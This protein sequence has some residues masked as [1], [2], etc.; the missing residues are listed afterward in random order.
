MPEF[1][2]R[3]EY[4][5][6]KSEKI[7]SNLERLQRYQ[8]GREKPEN[9]PPELQGS[10]PLSRVEGMRP[11]DKLF[12]ESWELYKVRFLTLISLYLL[13]VLLMLA[14]LGAFVGIA[15]FFSL[16]F[17]VSKDALIAGGVFVGI[18]SGF[19]AMLWGVAAFT[20]AVVDE[21]TGI[22]DALYKGWQKVSSFMW[23]FSL[24]GFV[25]TGGFLL[26][27][28]PG[29]VFLVW[30]TFAQFILASEGDR[31]M[32]A[33]LKSKEYVK[34]N[35]FDVFLRLF[36]IWLMSILIGIVPFIG[37][38]LSIAFFPFVMIFICLIYQDL[39][40]LKGDGMEYP[41]SEGEKFKWI[42][43][44]ALGY[45]MLLI[46]LIALLFITATMPLLLKGMFR[47]L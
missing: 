23:L 18:I 42:G 3:E 17:P 12:E 2:N 32:D 13:S 28:I 34:G 27:I 9:L 43:I 10:H 38:F 36:V 26:F 35:W 1:K 44:G 7:K 5:R 8:R 22:K 20:Y 31:G 19:M 30:F 11:F 16:F 40:G 39:R 37:P 29:I 15:Y 41:H 33:L 6:W 25:V 45:I 24:V 4:E 14:P 46:T 21:T 47:S